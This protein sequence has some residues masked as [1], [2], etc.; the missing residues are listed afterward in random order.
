VEVR[1]EDRSQA[2]QRL[3]TFERREAGAPVLLADALAAVHQVDVP[4][5]DDGG[6]DALA[7]AVPD[8]PSSGP[9]QDEAGPVALGFDRRRLTAGTRLRAGTIARERLHL[10]DHVAHRAIVYGRDVAD[11]LLFD[12]DETLMVEEPAAVAAFRATAMRAGA[13]YEVDVDALAVAAR[14]RARELS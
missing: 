10:P 7:V 1:Q 3:A 9:E 11:V 5:D 12:L 4:V 8:R 14:G 13:I 2:P 6:R